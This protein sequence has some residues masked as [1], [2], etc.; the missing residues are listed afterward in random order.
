MQKV[1]GIKR[2][3]VLLSC[4]V[5]VM[6]MFML[7]IH[8]VN[9]ASS[10]LRIYNKTGGDFV[11]GCSKATVSYKAQSKSTRVSIKIQDS[12]G[13]TVYK[14]TLKNIK[15]GKTY[16]FVWNGKNLNGQYVS[17][18][19]YR[20]VVNIN[21]KTIKSSTIKFLKKIFAGEMVQ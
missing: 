14:K 5:G 8:T 20:A 15:K 1:G 3:T 13:K 2:L 6:F 10:T 9:A 18:G 7:C 11:K 16:S 21:G 4:L 19:K 17:S 12:S